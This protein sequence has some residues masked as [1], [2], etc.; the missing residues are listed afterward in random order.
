M[1]SP[2]TVLGVVDKPGASWA[3]AAQIAVDR[4]ERKN[5][6]AGNLLPDCDRAGIHGA[7]SKHP[8]SLCHRFR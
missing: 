6:S 7:D 5:A 2:A 8:I 4:R 3:A 1:F